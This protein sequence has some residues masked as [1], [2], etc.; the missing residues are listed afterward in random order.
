MTLFKSPPTSNEEVGYKP[1]FHRRFFL[2]EVK[3]SAPC[4]KA[5]TMDSNYE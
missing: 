4:M 3:I 5:R 1:D 2:G